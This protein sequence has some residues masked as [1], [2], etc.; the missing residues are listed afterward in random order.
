MYFGSSAGVRLFREQGM[1]AIFLPVFR[2]DG[3]GWLVTTPYFQ[4]ALNKD[5]E[6]DGS[7]REMAM[8]VLKVM[9]SQEAQNIIC[10]G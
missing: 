6:Q 2:E 10:D 5:L 4:V 8:R 3:D 1:D 9:L 7:R